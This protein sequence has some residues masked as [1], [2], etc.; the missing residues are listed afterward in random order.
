M[1]NPVFLT[2]LSKTDL[3]K[4]LNSGKLLE[5]IARQTGLGETYLRKLLNNGR[6][7]EWLE[8]LLAI[9][10]TGLPLTVGVTEAAHWTGLTETYLRELLNNGKLTAIQDGRLVRI[11]RRHLQE[12]ELMTPEDVASWLAIPRSWVCSQARAGRLPCVRLGKPYR[13]AKPDLVKHFGFAWRVP[14]GRVSIPL[15]TPDD[16]AELLSVPV[17][18]V[19][20]WVRL[21]TTSRGGDFN[22]PK[23]P[24]PHVRFGRY[25]RFH[26][27]DLVTWFNG[28]RHRSV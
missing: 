19:Y 12:L 26:E 11:R 18:T 14:P 27:A 17:K 10:P 28:P 22:G 23:H 6:L 25:V 16:A 4:L 21:P 7:V 8:Y 15:L 24:A 13:F 20:Q 1:K 3:R 5:E 2:E 9:D